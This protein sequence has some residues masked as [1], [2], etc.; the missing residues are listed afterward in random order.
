V[1]G[2]VWSGIAT[3]LFSRMPEDWNS[4]DG[5]GGRVDDRGVSRNRIEETPVR[6][7]QPS[8]DAITSAPRPATPGGEH[9]EPLLESPEQGDRLVILSIFCFLLVAFASQFNVI[10]LL[11][12]YGVISSLFGGTFADNSQG[13][14]YLLAALAHTVPFGLL[15]LLVDQFARKCSRPTRGWARV[16]V[17]AF[18]LAFWVF[19]HVVIFVWWGDRLP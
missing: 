11:G 8:A 16:G 2:G 18:Y 7:D 6:N 9:P 5:K 14:G 3:R 15:Y 17:T 19:W 12:C 10:I 13:L 1:G 4:V